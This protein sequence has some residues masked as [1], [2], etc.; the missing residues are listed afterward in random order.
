M[1]TEQASH[2]PETGLKELEE[3]DEEL[4][5]LPDPPKKERTFTVVLLG[6]TAL[7]SLA[8]VFALWRDAAYAFAPKA[9]LDLGDL[10][11]T[12]LESFGRSDSAT[13]DNRLVRAHGML[14]AAGAIR[15]ER[16]FERDTYRVSPV[17]GRSD[18]WVEVR[19]PVGE[20]NARYV[21]PSSFAGRLVSLDSAGTKHRGLRSAIESTTGQPVP[22]RAWLLVDGESPSNARWAVALITLFLGFAVWNVMTIARLLKRVH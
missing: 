11:E 14:G 5:A 6:V 3:L 12:P 15:Y 13:I 21:P 2:P 1:R 20:E 19:V 22:A 10:R 16:P 7:A 9:A 17:A 4:L 18:V 8:M